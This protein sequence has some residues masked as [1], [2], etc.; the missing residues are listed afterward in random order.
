M[1]KVFAFVPAV[2]LVSSVLFKNSVASDEWNSWWKW[3]YRLDWVFFLPKFLGYVIYA[4]LKEASGDIFYQASMF[5]LILE[6][7]SLASI[8]YA[9]SLTTAQMPQLA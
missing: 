9:K 4:I 8:Y 3:Q 5:S 6:I 7:G 2:D 1:M